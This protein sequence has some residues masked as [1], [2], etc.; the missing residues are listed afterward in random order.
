M[1]PEV[2]P[3]SAP[4]S[5]SSVRGDHPL[6][7][8]TGW[9]LLL[10]T[11]GPGLVVMLADTDAGSAIVAAQSGA[12]WGY[13]LLLLQM[14]LVPVLYLVQELTVRLGLTTQKGHGEL[15]AEHWGM[16]WAW[17]SVGTLL[18]S[19]LGAMLT[20]F[21]G[22]AGV[23]LLFGIPASITIVATVVFLVVIVTTGTY[24]KV[25]LVA[26]GLGLF[27]LAFV[28]VALVARPSG[29][30]M[31]GGLTQIPLGNR[32]YLLLVAGN[33][34]AVIM[35]W[36]V[37]YQQ[38]AV[39]DKG[40]DLSHLKA[41]RWDTAVG[42]VVTQVIMASILIL[43]AATIGAHRPDTPLDTV[44]EIA[45]AL[46]PFLGSLWGRLVFALGMAGAAL[47]ATIVVSLTA[48][49]GLGEVTGYRHSLA[50]H[51]LEAP[52]FY[53]AYVAGLVVSAGVVL[54]GFNLVKVAVTVNVMNALLL[55][56]VLG[57]LYM[58][59]RRALPAHC[60]LTTWESWLVG[61]TV[62]L[63]AGLG[64]YAGIVGVGAL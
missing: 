15:I 57:F 38:S 5:P 1:S 37:F 59:A 45:E 50:C 63:T 16:G 56:I 7:H 33:V 47:V 29:P 27:E 2:L 60:R 51:P 34:G 32:D 25:E 24:R 30:A 14:L 53:A 39:V 18:V 13:R 4:S 3:P 54:S 31:L 20:E 43:V 36:M 64:V 19:C 49:W 22:L 42:A 9:K 21:A 35:P 44:Q 26:I 58:L 12:R 52:W 6:H 61:V 28:A 48:A 40:L 17:L 8:L 46:T 10:F 11:I 55:P 41:S 23:G 62:L